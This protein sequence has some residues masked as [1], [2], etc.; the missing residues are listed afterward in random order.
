MRKTILSAAA[1]LA[2]AGIAGAQENPAATA[3]PSYVIG[4]N[5]AQNMKSQGVEVNLDS[6]LAGMKD[7]LHGKGSKFSQAEAQEIMSKFQADMQT[8][9]AAKA[10]AS[11]KTNADEGKAFLEKNG[12]AEGVKTTASG[13]QYQVIK[14]GTG[15]KP[16]ATDK[17]KVH[18]HGT[19]LN[20][21]VFDSS[22]DK[23]EPISFP[24][25][26]V[27]KGWTEGVQLMPVGS[28][29]KFF[30]PS[31]LAYGSRGAGNDIGPNATL[32]F[33]VELLDIEKE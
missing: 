23:G 17:V 10:E 29:Y 33:E 3:D 18:Y 6:L 30:I 28:K 25:D 22:V 20:G 8:K 11:S 16:K 1:G 7:V 4:T 14:E 27:I 24:L 12:K 32:I 9:A 21:T 19:L 2:M 31:E 13:L 26:G 5:I 15:A